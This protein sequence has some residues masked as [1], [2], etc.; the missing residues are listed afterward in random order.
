MVPLATAGTTVALIALAAWAAVLTVVVLA[1]IRQIAVLG[2]R[3]DKSLY[4]GIDPVDDGPA[5]GS[6]MPPQVAELFPAGPDA[7]PAF[8]MLMANTCTTCHDIAFELTGTTFD[9]PIVTLVAGRPEL[10]QA[11]VEALPSSVTIVRDPEATSAARALEVKTT[12][13]VFEFRRGQL[14]AKAA[15]RGAD[16][17]RRFIS[18]A[19]TVT[20][21]ELADSHA[22]EEGSE[23]VRVR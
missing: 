14:A 15:L 2:L 12:P 3:I 18:E 20:D 1:C 9:V 17:L 4:S 16:H 23:D 5:L 7:G 6:P 11:L 22:R 8:V 10:V 13:F 19:S 21:E